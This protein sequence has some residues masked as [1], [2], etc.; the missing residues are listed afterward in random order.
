MNQYVSRKAQD[1]GE[2]IGLVF[3]MLLNTSE[4]QTCSNSHTS[5]SGAVIHCLKRF[6]GCRAQDAIFFPMR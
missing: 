6:G 3:S 5:T 2:H 4:H 1:S